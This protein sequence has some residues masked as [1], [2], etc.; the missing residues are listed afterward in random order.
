MVPEHA[1]LTNRLGALP[2][3]PR[4]I[5]ETKKHSERVSKGLV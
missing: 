4:S 1:R 5:F 2:P 3:D